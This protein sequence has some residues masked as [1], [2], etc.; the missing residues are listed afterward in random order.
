M[1]ATEAVSSPDSDVDTSPDSDNDTNRLV[2]VDESPF[3]ACYA[4]ED[5]DVFS[6]IRSIRLNSYLL[7]LKRNHL[8]S[9]HLY[10]RSTL[11]L[12]HWTHWS[13][14]AGMVA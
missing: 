11:F 12:L 8:F 4:D 6:W 2:T 13:L 3:S 7:S 10:F 1:E 14:H 5:E 9:Y